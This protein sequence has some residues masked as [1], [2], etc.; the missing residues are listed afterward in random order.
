MVKYQII[1]I[2]IFFFSCTAKEEKLSFWIGGAPQEILFWQELIEDFENE[3]KIKV[4]F[5]RQP[6][7]TDQR[8]QGLITS[9]VARQSDPDVFLM[10]VVW[11]KQF[12]ESGW[13]E[14]FDQYIRQSNF[15]MQP[16]FKRVIDLSDRY[17]GILYALPVFID[18]GL[19]YYRSDLLQKYNFPGP[20]KTWNQLVQYSRYIQKQER[21]TNPSF[22]GFIWQ[23]AQYEGLVC[24]FLE[25]VYSNRVNNEIKQEYIYLNKSIEKVLELFYNTLM[26]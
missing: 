7:Y 26:E 1:I 24:T 4:E 13:L 22:N 6:T 15:S 3:N 11:I 23:G 8:R 5:V 12:V 16:F 2:T 10:D 9:L 20:P 14:P 21:K 25:Y 19:M 17:D 18:I